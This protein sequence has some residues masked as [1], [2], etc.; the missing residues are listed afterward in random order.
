MKA[1]YLKKPKDISIKEVEYPHR[2]PNEVLIKVKAVGICG[3]DEGAYKGINPLVTYPR[4]LGHEIVGELF[5]IPSEEK[6]L[7]VGDRVVVEPYIYCGH[8]YP[9][10]INRTNCCENMKVLG[11]HV[12]GGFTEFLAHDKKLVHKIPENIPWEQAPMIEPL[13]IALHSVNRSRLK[14]SEHVIISGA[15]PIG[16]LIAQAAIIKGAIPI[17]IDLVQERLDL[18]KH[19]GIP[20]TFNLKEGDPLVF[21]QKITN[22]RMAEV[23][24]EASGASKAIRNA[25]DYVSYA[26]RIVFV[27]WPKEEISMPTA[28]FSKKELDIYGSR[29]GVSSDFYE[30]IEIISK[31]RINVKDLITKVVSIDQLPEAMIEKSAHPDR[32][33][34]IT[35]VL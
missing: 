26:G 12:D 5:E 3:S 15:G 9:C 32:F 8:C 21:I 28:L 2:K 22:R 11:V 6:D 10:S 4:I 27:G 20:H 30:A 25:I 17:L 18:A 31:N 7:K 34:K 33:M 24:I 14:D 23:V 13:V 16:I 1:V 19:L 35:S 29:N